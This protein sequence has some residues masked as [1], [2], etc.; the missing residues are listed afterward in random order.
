MRWAISVFLIY[1][2]I[3]LCFF[4]LAMFLV[5]DY[6]SEVAQQSPTMRKSGPIGQYVFTMFCALFWPVGVYVLIMKLL[7]KEP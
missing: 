5:R 3:G 7:G 6:K 1:W 2:I 4:L